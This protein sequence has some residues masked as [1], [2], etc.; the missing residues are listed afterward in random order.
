MPDLSPAPPPLRGLQWCSGAEFLEVLF[1]P[2][3][4]RRTPLRSILAAMIERTPPEARRGATAALDAWLDAL[5][6]RPLEEAP[7]LWGPLLQ[8]LCFEDAP[9]RPTAVRGDP[10]TLLSA[11]W[12]TSAQSLQRIA[13][14]LHTHRALCIE[15][16]DLEE[17]QQILRAL[18][19]ELWGY[20]LL[21][22]P[23]G[24]SAA[25]MSAWL[26]QVFELH[27]VSDTQSTKER[28]EQ[29]RLPIAL[30]RT[31]DDAQIYRGLWTLLVEPTQ[32]QRCALLSQAD[33]ETWSC[34]HFSAP[35]PQPTLLVRPQDH[36]CLIIAR[37]GWS[38]QHAHGL[39]VFQLEPGPRADEL[40]RCLDALAPGAHAV[41]SPTG[42]AED[43]PQPTDSAEEHPL[44]APS[45]ELRALTEAAVEL[46]RMM[47]IFESNAPALSVQL[48]Q[49]AVAAWQSTAEPEIA[50]AAAPP[51]LAA[52]LDEACVALIA[53][54]CLHWPRSAL[55]ALLAYLKQQP[56]PLLSALVQRH[57]RTPDLQLD[58][59]ARA[60]DRD[61]PGETPR[62]PQ[63]ESCVHLEESP[64]ILKVSAWARRP[65]LKSSWRLPQ[66]I[67]HLE[68]QL[69]LT[70]P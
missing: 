36:R 1:G 45:A 22:L 30:F 51:Q 28:D 33:Q 32:T 20:G 7:H 18:C 24:L 6:Q 5:P 65:G 42:S 8:K 35:S 68:A 67:T 57:V 15:A 61:Y 50:E 9:L 25:Q 58:R 12:A 39:P 31:L 69:H 3:Q 34:L 26:A 4:R 16:D 17:A 59:L 27:W 47:R 29:R 70:A 44:P 60:L 56:G 55:E 38:R 14:G 54:R 43:R 41:Q 52:A 2:A 37:R 53:P 13:V 10:I 66:L 21:A 49:H 64:L 62:L 40:H 19:Q 23:P 11:R 46:V 63:D 48:S